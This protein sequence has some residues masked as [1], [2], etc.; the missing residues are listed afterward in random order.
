MGDFYNINKHFILL[1][2]LLISSFS[3]GQFQGMIDNSFTSGFSIPP[4][5]TVS[6]VLC[7]AIDTDGKIFL[8]G[9]FA[10]YNGQEKV[11]LLKLNTDGSLDNNFN[12]GSGTLC[13]TQA[14]LINQIAI[15][16]DGKI[17]C[18]GA[19]ITFNCIARSKIVRL[20]TDGSVDNTF[21][22]G[23]G[24][25]GN[26]I[27]VFI[28]NDGKILI[29]GL[30]TSYNG[31]VKKSLARLNSDGSLDTSFNSGVGIAFSFGT[32]EIWTINVQSDNKILI[33]GNFTSF[34]GFSSAGIARLNSS[35]NFDNSFNIGTGSSG[36]VSSIKILDDSKLIITGSFQNFN[37]IPKSR[38]IKL[39]SDGSTD[40][41]FISPNSINAIIRTSSIQSDGKILIGGNFTQIDSYLINRIYRL[42][43]NGSLDSTFIQGYGANNNVR[44][45]IIQTDGKILIGGE[46]TTYNNIQSVGVVR[47]DGLN[48]LS[49]NENQFSEGNIKC[50]PNPTNGIVNISTPKTIEQIN[51]YD[52]TGR[53]LQSIKCNNANEKVDIQDL[54]NAM[55][56]M[57]VKTQEGVKTVKIVKQ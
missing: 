28:Q 37:G 34:D 11:C 21:N 12:I 10:E 25:N 51:V 39:N 53:L 47:L 35:G 43:E 45:S 19:F 17:I 32:P 54:P 7:S 1:F 55:Y 20:N 5:N 48:L 18:V 42:N 33:G 26:I 6:N 31:V 29:G 49:T 4:V 3:F 41:T 56:L 13:G 22:P 9:A 2:S 16:S 38:I 23:T 8:G 52:K 14:G 40:N 44:T 15:Q 50:Y 57:V 36:S 24:A 30:F 27:S 46:F